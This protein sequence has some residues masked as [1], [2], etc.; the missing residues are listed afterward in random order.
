MKMRIA[1]TGG[2]GFIGRQLA[3]RMIADGHQVVL[4]AR[5]ERLEETAFPTSQVQFLANDLSDPKALAE[6]FAGCDA[7]AHCAGINREI[8]KQTYRQVHVEGTKHVVQ[9]AQQAGVKRIALM[10]FLR[11]RP[12]CGSGYHESKWLAERIVRDSGLDYTIIRAGVVYGLGDHMLDHL[13]HALHTFPFFALVGLREKQMQPLAIEDLVN[14]LRASLVLGRLARQTVA[15][16]GPEQ[17]YLSAAVKRVAAVLGK[18]PMFFPAPLWFHYLLAFGCELT[19]K[20]PMVARAQVRILSEGI[21]EPALSCD[22]LPY[23]LKPTRRFSEEQIRAGLPAAESFG[24]SDLRRC[25]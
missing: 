8:G 10:S 3:Q 23:D 2:T 17:L 11:A 21:V 19:M 7:V 5:S 16:V 12:N 25:A 9:A 20:V 14:V 22:P 13:S 4:I 24:V 1:I 6:A 15:V 18:K